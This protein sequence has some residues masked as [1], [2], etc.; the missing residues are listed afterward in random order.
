MISGRLANRKR[1]GYSTLSTDV[2]AVWRIPGGDPVF[3]VN[4]SVK[5]IANGE[6]TEQGIATEV[7][8]KV[9]P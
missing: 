4:A 7:V 8:K 5:F 6:I 1:D 2:P 3:G 9:S